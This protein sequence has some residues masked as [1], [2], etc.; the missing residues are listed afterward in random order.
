MNLIFDSIL[1]PIIAYTKSN[2]FSSLIIKKFEQVIV[3]NND[4]LLVINDSILNKYFFEHLFCIKSNLIL[5]QLIKTQGDLLIS[6]INVDDRISLII[7]KPSTKLKNREIIIS[8]KINILEEISN[9]KGILEEIVVIS[10]DI[11]EHHHN[12]KPCLK[13][14]NL[15]EHI[16]FLDPDKIFIPSISK[17]SI[18]IIYALLSH[19]ID[20]FTIGHNGND[21]ETQWLILSDT[22]NIP[23][24]LSKKILK[25]L[26]K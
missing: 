5:P 8:K 4:E 13:N 19:G 17:A 26:L 1:K 24:E 12:L 15:I 25:N 23:Y 2:N 14:N 18:K 11:F 9:S 20:N 16:F 21:F 22:I 3:K 10:S 6:W 7:K